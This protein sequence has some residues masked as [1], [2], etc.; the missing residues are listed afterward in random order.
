MSKESAQTKRTKKAVGRGTAA[1]LRAGAQSRT[2]ARALSSNT[3][4][5]SRKE[6]TKRGGPG[7]AGTNGGQRDDSPQAGATRSKRTATRG[8]G[9]KARAGA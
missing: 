6:L 4:G 1:G 7:R 9:D 2:E 5:Q 8:R 3:G